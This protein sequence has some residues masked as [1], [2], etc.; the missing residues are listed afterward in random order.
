[1]TSSAQ[2]QAAGFEGTGFL[3]DNGS[4]PVCCTPEFMNAYGVGLDSTFGDGE[5]TGLLRE[6][7]AESAL[8]GL[9]PTVYEGLQGDAEELS[10]I[11]D[12]ILTLAKT[13]GKGVDLDVAYDLAELDNLDTI[14]LADLRTRLTADGNDNRKIT[15]EDKQVSDMTDEELTAALTDE[16]DFAREI[17]I[18][19]AKAE[20]LLDDNEDLKTMVTNFFG[21]DTIAAEGGIGNILVNTVLSSLDVDNGNDDYE[22]GNGDQNGGNNLTLTNSDVEGIGSQP[23]MSIGE[24]FQISIE[25]NAFMSVF[26]SAGNGETVAEFTQTL[27]TAV[28]QGDMGTLNT[29]ADAAGV[30]PEQLQIIASAMA[31]NHS[32]LMATAGS[33][34]TSAKNG[35]HEYLNNI[36][37]DND[38]AFQFMHVGN[39]GM[40]DSKNVNDGTYGAGDVEGNDNINMDGDFS[41]DKAADD[42]DNAVT[43]FNAGDNGQGTNG[44][45]GQVGDGTSVTG[46]DDAV[47]FEAPL[48]TLADNVG[49][50]NMD[51]VGLDILTELNNVNAGTT[52]FNESTVKIGETDYNVSLEQSEDFENPGL[53]VVIIT[54]RDETG[55]VAYSMTA[56]E[57]PDSGSLIEYNTEVQK[58]F[59]DTGKDA[60]SMEDSTGYTIENGT[61]DRGEGEGEG[62]F[63]GPQ[64]DDLGNPLFIG[65]KPLDDSA[66]N[67]EAVPVPV[68]ATGIS[69]IEDELADLSDY[70]KGIIAALGLPPETPITTYGNGP[71]G[72]IGSIAVDGTVIPLEA[73]V[74]DD[75][76]VGTL[77]PIQDPDA[78]WDQPIQK[79]DEEANEGKGGYVDVVDERTAAAYADPLGLEEGQSAL[80]ENL[81]NTINGYNSEGISSS[82]L[83]LSSNVE[84]YDISIIDMVESTKVTGAYVLTV[85]AQDK[86]TGQTQQFQIMTYE[87]QQ[88]LLTDEGEL[89]P[90][91]EFDSFEDFATNAG[92]FNAAQ[93]LSSDGTQ[94]DGSVIGEDSESLP[95]GSL[96]ADATEFEF[97]SDDGVD[98]NNPDASLATVRMVDAEGEERTFQISIGTD[99]TGKATYTLVGEEKEV[100]TADGTKTVIE[101]GQ[102]APILRALSAGTDMAVS[103]NGYAFTVLSETEDRI[104]AQFIDQDGTV[105]I[106]TLSKETDDEGVTSY[107][108]IEEVEIKAT[109]DEDDNPMVE[110]T[111]LKVKAFEGLGQYQVLPNDVSVNDYTFASQDLTETEADALDIDLPDDAKAQEVIF[112]DGSGFPQKF[113]MILDENG[114]YTSFKEITEGAEDTDFYPIPATGS[115]MT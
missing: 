7:Q 21:E 49:A 112:D 60:F 32:N 111:A 29:I 27:F 57:H 55:A 106:F 5:V 53:D 96:S 95:L 61:V 80:G 44:G 105:R 18:L 86:Y 73:E 41:N 71:N 45:F 93:G 114:N 89:P 103:V 65:F 69:T 97:V 113:I 23:V 54:L 56:S 51:T 42:E 115:S 36:D 72:S 1:M 14:D 40:G 33:F 12:D 24:L 101:D 16:I 102:K 34:D 19:S 76:L 2:S 17:K 62:I 39:F 11:Q 90:E 30:S 104:S 31:N 6:D 109:T 107:A 64:V 25:V 20:A 4:V 88:I 82:D 47:G 9:Y 70:Q 91:S 98:P 37:G 13:Q 94:T 100:E 99:D 15:G 66:N 81:Y 75:S 10:K 28:S 48:E 108:L 67:E 46:F 84:N 52:L 79:W 77:T 68:E 50:E 85:N 26:A 58:A 87:G 63:T 110:N 83:P 38:Q 35:A 43:I 92:V 59:G 78:A 22:D 8:M 3:Y 74:A